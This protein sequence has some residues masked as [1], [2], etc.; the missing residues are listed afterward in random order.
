M[1]V[2]LDT[3]TGKKC[4][5]LFNIFFPPIV[6]GPHTQTTRI[7]PLPVEEPKKKNKKGKDEE[8]PPP[9]QIGTFEQGP[10]LYGCMGGAP[11]PKTALLNS[12]PLL[13]VNVDV[14][15]RQRALEDI[16]VCFFYFFI[17]FIYD[18]LFVNAGIEIRWRALEDI[19]VCLYV[20]CTFVWG[21]P[22][23][24]DYLFICE[25]CSACLCQRALE[26]INVCVYIMCI[27]V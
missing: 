8:P 4:V 2:L 26:D 1:C 13:S 18:C 11:L 19:K 6:L 27:F 10:F 16:E 12:V 17:F 25:G 23:I 14:E 20:T 21:T 22:L 9:P 5:P 3:H 15:M 7:Y 24:H